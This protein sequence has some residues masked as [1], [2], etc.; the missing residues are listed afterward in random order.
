MFSLDS[1]LEAQVVKIEG[2]IAA[3]PSWRG[4]DG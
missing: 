2:D 4:P 1:H 3:R